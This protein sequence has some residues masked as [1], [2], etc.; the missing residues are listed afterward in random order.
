MPLST[1]LPTP[2]RSQDQITRSKDAQYWSSRLL[3]GNTL[4]TRLTALALAAGGLGLSGQSAI[5][6]RE[7]RINRDPNTGT[8]EI[9]QNAFDLKTGP[10][11][12]TSNIPLPPGLPD[13]TVE[14]QSIFPAAEFV[15]GL[16][17]PNSVELTT[18]FDFINQ[19]FTNT[20]NQGDG[21][22]NY[23]LERNS[24]VTTTEFDINYVEGDH[25]FGEG[26]QVTV[27]DEDNNILRQE[28]RFV[29]GDGVT[30]GPNGE[31]LP[32]SGRISVTYGVNDRVELRVLNLRE[33]NAQPTQSGV[34]FTRDRQLIA[35]DFQDGGDR[36]FDDGE[37]LDVP[38]GSGEADALE[39]AT[40]TSIETR[41]EATE[42]EP[43]IRRESLVES[44]EIETTTEV[45]EDIIAEDREFGSVDAPDSLANRLGHAVGKRTE[46][47]ELLVY[48]RYASTARVRAGSDGLGVTG[49][50][51]PLIGNPKA[52]PTLF[53]A[54][55]TFDPFAG[56]NE[57][58]FSTT[59]GITQFLT[60]T[61][62]TATDVFDN[63]ITAV[64]S[65]DRLLEPTGLFNNR[66]MVGYVPARGDQLSSDGGIFTL[67]QSQ[68]IVIQPPNP[69]A[70][71]RGN[72]AYTDNVGGFI[73]EDAAGDLTF[74][75]QWSRDGYRQDATTLNPGE[76]RRVI[77]ALVPQQAGQNLQLNQNYAVEAI[78]SEYRIA[79]GSFTIISADQH[80]ENFYQE[81]AEIYTVEDTLS[82]IN[83]AAT[84]VFNGIRGLYVEPSSNELIPT[85]DPDIPALADARVGNDL[86]LIFEGQSAYSR[87]TRAAGLYLGGALTGG[88]GNQEDRITAVRSTVE[89]ATDSLL[90]RRRINTFSTPRSQVLS[91]TIETTTTT[92]RDGRASFNINDNGRLEQVAFT[93]TSEARNTG[94]NSRDLETTDDIRLGEESQIDSFTEETVEDLGTRIVAAD[95]STSS[96]TDS[97]ANAS[98][99]RGEIALGGVLNFGNTPWSPA[100]NTVRAELFARDTVIG[101]S[102]DDSEVGWR[103]QATFYPLGEVKREG[104]Q[105]D[106]FGN[107]VPLYQTEPDMDANGQRKVDLLPLDNGDMVEVP[108]SK[109]VV[110]ENG[111][112]VAQEV[113]TG[114][115]KGPGVYL[116]VED[117]WDDGD[118]AVVDGGLQFTF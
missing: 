36:D 26:I 84:A 91:T 35:E 9:D 106:E 54:D 18:D 21:G 113:G 100:A 76:A 83:N 90:T 10:L 11:T 92:E 49:Q 30:I 42:L 19:S 98:P 22:L 80:P 27:F 105:Y 25:S 64:D 86:N 103:A 66:R 117:A 46:D 94:T 109:F 47:G 69:Q 33:N 114:R 52:P 57:A 75:P 71:G 88:I 93:P 62:R 60:R 111:D 65:D 95:Q 74:V 48:D 38:S 107:L 81:T 41:E 14:G 37:Y 89:T 12:N 40:D 32:S 17:A 59:L 13:G 53:S 6:Q 4:I 39:Q 96:D 63:E 1:P 85:V 82:D 102:S 50:L 2:L 99:I 72:A 112:R 43:E 110:D 8:V 68:Q 29:R 97:Y 58:G 51:R 77:Y 67:P 31:E 73:L 55:A 5:A 45:S 118:G 79:D 20:L 3:R 78:G 16:L 104:Y 7:V 23:T 34:Y 87:T 56:D 24:L 61:H 108:V 15:P 70:V 44:E 101:R 116:R 28:Q 115:P